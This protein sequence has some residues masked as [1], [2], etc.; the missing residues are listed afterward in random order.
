MKAKRLSIGLVAVIGCTALF[1]VSCSPPKPVTKITFLEKISVNNEDTTD[2]SLKFKGDPHSGTY[3][4][5]TDSAY[6]YGNG[7]IFMIAD[8]LV[9]KEL[10]VKV[11]MWARQ[12]DVG[13]ENQ[14]A[15]A[16]Q[17]GDSILNWSAVEFKKHINESN[18]W[19]NVKDSV[20]FPNFLIKEKGLSIKMY[21][22]N[23]KGKPYLD[24]DDIEIVIEKS[25]QVVL[26]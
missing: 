11:N 3:Y 9:E 1:I 7:T 20:V 21:S 10:K 4:S 19:V 23:P 18:K 5:H 15:I 25:E 8:S 16:L 24:T 12:G 2:G 22:F 13:G 14:F 26:D 6:M 17:K